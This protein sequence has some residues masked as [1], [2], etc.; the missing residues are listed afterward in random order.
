LKAYDKIEKKQLGQK[1]IAY[2]NYAQIY[3]KN[4]DALEREVRTT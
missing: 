4:P 3:N 1:L 2:F